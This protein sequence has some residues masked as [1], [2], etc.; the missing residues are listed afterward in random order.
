MPLFFFK[1]IDMEKAALFWSGGKD[2]AFAL[3]HVL[4]E[5][6]YRIEMLVTTLNSEFRRISMHGIREDVLDR[7]AAAA[8]IPLHKMW[9]DS[10]ST[11]ES[12]EKALMQTYCWLKEHGIT[13]I[14]FGDIFLEDLRVYREDLLKRAGLKGYF[15]LWKKNTRDL[16]LEALD[17]GFRTV[18]CCI[19]TSYL[20]RSWL[21]K[22]VDGTFIKELP[23]GVDPCGENGEFHTFCFAGPVFDKEITFAAG[24][25]EYKPL[26]INTVNKQEEAGFWYLDII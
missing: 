3:H 6:N 26:Q 21:G 4:K 11:N 7:Q 2:C 22:E 1:R 20:D 12:Y 9:V 14:I 17:R 15:P 13:V 5:K 24:R 19:N 16:I 25:K 10:T 18:T 8:G 23:H